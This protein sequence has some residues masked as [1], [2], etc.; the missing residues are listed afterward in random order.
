M[1]LTVEHHM[2][3]SRA[4]A[5]ASL[6]KHDHARGAGRARERWNRTME[7]NGGMEWNG[8]GCPACRMVLRMRVLH[9]Q[10]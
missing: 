3:V 6:T 1:T 7:W 9:H 2:T 10:R 4:S 5:I 8:N